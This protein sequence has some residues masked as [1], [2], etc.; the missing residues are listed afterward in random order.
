MRVAWFSPLPPEPSG[1]AVYNRHLLASLDAELAIDRFVDA[2]RHSTAVELQLRGMLPGSRHA[3]HSRR[4]FDAHDFIWKHERQPYDVIVYQLGNAS[5][6][7][8]IWAYLAR[9]PGLV[10]LHDP[11]LHH[12]RA[13]QL[14]KHG[15]FDDYRREFWYDHPDATRDFVEY[16]VE[17]L[18]GSI[19]YFW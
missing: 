15:R 18:G 6:H 3:P 19:Y 17:G 13:R 11:R 4:V 8:Y 7:D 9:Y 10:V 2:R 14:L 5:C 12:A 1:V 16:A